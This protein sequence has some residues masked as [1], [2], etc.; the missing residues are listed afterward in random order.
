MYTMLPEGEGMQWDG[1]YFSNASAAP[2]TAA[3]ALFRKCVFLFLQE[4]LNF[5]E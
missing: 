4:C 1:C 2:A 5:Q 3:V